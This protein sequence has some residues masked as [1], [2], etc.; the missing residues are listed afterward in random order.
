M[1]RT[2]TRFGVTTIERGNRRIEA[3]IDSTAR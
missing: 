3:A 2:L 1:P